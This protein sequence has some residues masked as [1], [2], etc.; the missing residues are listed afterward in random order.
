[1]VDISYQLL[2]AR[3][4][5]N[6][7]TVLRKQIHGAH[8]AE[9]IEYVHQSR[10]ASRRIRAGLRMF[11]ECFPARHIKK[12][13]KEIKKVTKRLGAARDADVQI[14]FIRQQLTELK[15]EQK[16]FSPGIRRLLLRLRQKR[17]AVQPKV[18]KAI[19]NFEAGPFMSDL[20][21]EI[22][23]ILFN[24]NPMEKDIQSPFVFRQVY[25]RIHKQLDELLSREQALNDAEN[26]KGHHQMRISAKRLRYTLEI[27]NLAYEK[28][29][30]DIIKRMKKLQTTLGHLHDCDV[31]I[32]YLPVFTEQ[33]NQ[34]TLDYYGHARAFSR[35]KPGLDYLLQERIKQR[36]ILF[37]SLCEL[38]AR[39]HKEGIWEELE[40][41]LQSRLEKHKQKPETVT[42]A[43]ETQ[44]NEASST[45]DSIDK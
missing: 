42:V 14:E 7:L 11:S 2:A 4:L 3:Y 15:K 20:H 22:E 36:K 24:R 12:W 21:G 16:A 5:Q 32:E 40:S 1:M 10:V 31:W 45:K 8:T 17:R 18:I 13:R 33:E 35:L 41:I 27:C 34:K 30:G 43:G 25:E 26:V 19:D 9:D 37:D 23:K 39:I 44:G 6:Q 29:L 38:W 28:A